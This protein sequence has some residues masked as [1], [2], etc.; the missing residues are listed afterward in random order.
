MMFQFAAL[1]PLNCLLSVSGA[2]AIIRQHKAACLRITALLACK[3]L[4]WIGT[5]A[6]EDPLS[7]H[8]VHHCCDDPTVGSHESGLPGLNKG[9]F[10]TGVVLTL[11]IPAVSAGTNAA[12]LKSPLV[13]MGS[14]HGH[15]GHVRFLTSIELPEGFDMKFPPMTADSS[16]KRNPNKESNVIV[17]MGNFNGPTFFSQLTSARAAV[18]LTVTYIGV[19]LHAAELQPTSHRKLTTL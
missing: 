5:S 14:A 17:N 7:W 3:D 18:Q 2:D 10:H 1:S 15:T 4:L 8:S 16:G 19:T 12:S 9:S 13:P 6:G 11:A